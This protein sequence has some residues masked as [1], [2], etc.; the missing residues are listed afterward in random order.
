MGSLH[1]SPDDSEN[2][3]RSVAMKLLSGG[4][5]LRKAKHGVLD[6]L[7]LRGGAAATDDTKSEGK[8]KGT[9][10]G[11]DL[12]N[13]ITPSY[14]AWGPDGQRLVGDSAKNQAA[15]NPTNTVFDVMQ[16][17][18]ME[19]SAV[20]QIVLV[21]GST[22]IPKAATGT[23]SESSSSADAAADV[24]PNPDE[25]SSG[26]GPTVEEG[27]NLR[28][29]AQGVWLR[30]AEQWFQPLLVIPRLNHSA[31]SPSWT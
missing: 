1:S 22:R 7:G 2:F 16:D 20:S 4:S 27:S 9:C 28:G 14:V 15:S 21:G 6:M 29:H 12:G 10:I 17:A 8:I 23:G 13:R 19:K 30:I 31:K 26:G 24:P 11:I 18:N 3:R 5:F 25:G